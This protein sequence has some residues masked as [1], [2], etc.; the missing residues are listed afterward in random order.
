MKFL[1]PMAGALL[2]AATALPAAA[3]PMAMDVPVNMGALEIA[4]SGVG[5][6]KDD[7]QWGTYPIRL[8]FSNGKAEYLAGEHVV[9]SQGGKTQADFECAG[10][11][12]LVKGPA[13]SYKATVTMLYGDQQGMTK[14]ATFAL[15]SGSQKRVVL[16]Y[17]PTEPRTPS[18][19][20]APDGASAATSGAVPP[21]GSGQ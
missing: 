9:L 8:E 3:E 7:P 19:M 2:A 13:G 12:V 11:W 21:A 18:V 15:G 4:C 1:S 17:G 6:A 16:Q 10:P 5:S 20:T 14:S